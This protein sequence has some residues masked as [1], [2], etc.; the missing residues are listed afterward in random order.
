MNIECLI[1]SDRGVLTAYAPDYF[2]FIEAVQRHSDKNGIKQTLIIKHETILYL[3]NFSEMLTEM[4]GIWNNM[5]WAGFIGLLTPSTLLYYI[6]SEVIPSLMKKRGDDGGVV[7]TPKPDIQKD[8][9]SPLIHSCDH[10]F[11]IGIDYGLRSYGDIRNQRH[12][13]WKLRDLIFRYEA[14]PH[15]V[16]FTNCI[17]VINGIIHTPYLFNDEIWATDGAVAMRS[18][19]GFNKNATLIDFTPM[20]GAQTV[21]L[22]SCTWTQAE[23]TMMYNVKL[24]TGINMT[25]RTAFLVLAGRLIYPH[26]FIR[27][28]DTA[29]KIN[30]WNYALDLMLLRNKCIREEFE[31]NTQTALD[32]AISNYIASLSTGFCR[33]SFLLIVNNAS[34][35][36]IKHQPLMTINK[37]DLKF[38][39]EAA[40]FLISVHT[41]EMFDYT[42]VEY[43][44]SK[45]VTKCYGTKF[46]FVKKTN[47]DDILAAIAYDSTGTEKK[48]FTDKLSSKDDEFELHDIVALA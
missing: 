29:I 35:K 14:T 12:L 4:Q 40:G 41:R 18:T 34:V 17:P 15:V 43:D 10:N 47:K 42:Y 31:Y 37:K 33:D 32:Q 13:N 38:H 22:N 45:L 39:N 9:V 27:L 21:G 20:G 19:T 44:N 2:T 23:S 8:C 24:P 1:E 26:E 48:W 46:D 6:T 16:D 28:S 3:V 5:T 30:F 7:Q 11:G 36:L 25:N